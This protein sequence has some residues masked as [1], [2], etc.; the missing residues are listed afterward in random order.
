MDHIKLNP[1]RHVAYSPRYRALVNGV[2]YCIARDRKVWYATTLAGTVVARA[3]TLKLLDDTLG[4]AMW[5]ALSCKY[6][7]TFDAAYDYREA[8]GI[9]SKARLI[10]FDGRGWTLQREVPSTPDVAKDTWTVA[11]YLNRIH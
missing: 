6:W 10:Y 2:R 7:R 8:H 5:S 4:E 9:M 3:R 11:Y 1:Y